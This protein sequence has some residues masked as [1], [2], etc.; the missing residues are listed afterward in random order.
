MI[1]LL[2]QRFIYLPKSLK[3][4]TYIVQCVTGIS[5]NEHNTIYIARCNYYIDS[6][7]TYFYTSDGKL[8]N[9]SDNTLV[10]NLIYQDR[11]NKLFKLR[12]CSMLVC[13]TFLKAEIVFR[14]TDIKINNT[15]IIQ[16]ML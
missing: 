15:V 8:Y 7:N 1:R 9:K 16:P 12:I 14:S 2:K 5:E 11:K 10:E 3:E 4:C 13:R 6:N